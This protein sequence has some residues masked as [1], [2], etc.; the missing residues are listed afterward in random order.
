[1]AWGLRWQTSLSEEMDYNTDTQKFSSEPV[2]PTAD[3]VFTYLFLIRLIVFG[4]E[5]PSV[6]QLLVI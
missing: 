5:A 4:Q 3:Q 2:I 1:M 6:L